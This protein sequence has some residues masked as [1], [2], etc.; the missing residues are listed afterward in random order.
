MKSFKKLI[1]KYCFSYPHD[2][3]SIK[4]QHIEAQSLDSE[5]PSHYM[6]SKC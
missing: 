2:V 1:L 4:I 6:K 5:T 3:V